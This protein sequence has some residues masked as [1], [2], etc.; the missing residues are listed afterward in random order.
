M[1]VID[2][3]DAPQPTPEVLK[4]LETAKQKK[5]VADQAFKAGD[6]QSGTHMSTI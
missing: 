5:D 3:E 2:A 4:K 1:A 6:L